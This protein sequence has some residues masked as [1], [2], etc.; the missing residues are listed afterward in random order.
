M[1]REC[2]NDPLGVPL[3]EAPRGWFGVI[4]S[5]PEQQE[6]LASMTNLPALPNS[7]RSEY[8]SSFLINNNS[9]L[10]VGQSTEVSAGR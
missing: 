5:F 8:F 6:W 2:E 9:G 3:K 7:P 10:P 4:P 1:G